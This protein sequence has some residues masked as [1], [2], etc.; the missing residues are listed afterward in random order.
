MRPRQDAF[1][2]PGFGIGVG[3]HIR[4]AAGHE[5]AFGTR[6]QLSIFEVISKPVAEHEVSV[7]IGM[8]VFKQMDMNVQSRRSDHAVSGFSDSKLISSFEKW[9]QIILFSGNICNRHQNIDKG[10]RRQSWDRRRT[11][12]FY[13]NRMASQRSPNLG[14]V[15]PSS[16]PP[17][18]TSG[19][20]S[21]G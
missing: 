5:L 21:D 6:V 14:Q 3:I 19:W 12:V 16:D 17:A 10:F 18:V 9:D 8:G 13:G 1:Y 2:D 4:K 11:N 7:D 15:G 20:G